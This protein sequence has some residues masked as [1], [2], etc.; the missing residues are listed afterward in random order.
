MGAYIAADVRR[1][2]LGLLETAR[3]LPPLL[4]QLRYPSP[5]LLAKRTVQV[6]GRAG[7]LARW[8]PHLWGTPFSRMG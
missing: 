2:L 4:G 6:G 5:R 8:N 7:W 1:F 3:E